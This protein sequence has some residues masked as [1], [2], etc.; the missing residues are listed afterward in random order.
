MSGQTHI[1]A[2]LAAAISDGIDLAPEIRTRLRNLIDT[3]PDQPARLRVMGHVLL[4][5]G[6]GSL[7][8]DAFG[9]ALLLDDLDPATHLGLTR[10]YLQ[11]GAR[12]TA[13]EHLEIAISLR[14][15]ARELRVVAAD[16]VGCRDKMRAFNQ[17]GAVL[18]ADP[19]HAGARKGLAALIRSVITNRIQEDKSATWKV[20][21]DT[22]RVWDL[23]DYMPAQELSPPQPWFLN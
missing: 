23:Q 12:E 5:M 19:D 14:P 10:T 7:A 21:V 13:L 16:L 20:S 4:D 22:A 17:L 15:D 2:G 6:L 8:L 9:R 18:S 1:S 11:N 3:L